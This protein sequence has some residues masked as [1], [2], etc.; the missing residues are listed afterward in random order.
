MYT[1]FLIYFLA[2]IAVNLIGYCINP[3]L[4]LFADSEGNLPSWLRWFQ[5]YDDTLD[6]KEP[7]FIESTSWLRTQERGVNDLSTTNT[8]GVAKN[9]ICTYV[10][11]VMW[12]YRNNAYGFAYSV[13]GAKSPFKTISE[14]GVNPS[15]RAPAI[16]GSYL[17][18]FEDADG[19]KYFQYKLVKDRGN[20]KCYEASIGWKTSGQ[21]V[22]R[23]TP[24]RKFN[25]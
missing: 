24:F 16:E 23:W 14:E 21:F 6:G 1:R 2:D 19:V 22:V 8:L 18:I 13:L 17:R 20:G 15:D 7:R 12:L 4:P 11:R 9:F 25:G 5:T 3:L 10:L